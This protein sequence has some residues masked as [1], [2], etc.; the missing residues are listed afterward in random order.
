LVLGARQSDDTVS[1]DVME[2]SG[3]VAHFWL[4]SSLSDRLRSNASLNQIGPK[5]LSIDLFKGYRMVY[6]SIK[7]GQNEPCK[8]TKYVSQQTESSRNSRD[9]VILRNTVVPMVTISSDLTNNPPVAI[10][11]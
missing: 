2:T 7:F 8:T 9:F 6:K 3:V 11:G 5:K 4:P 10:F 1:R